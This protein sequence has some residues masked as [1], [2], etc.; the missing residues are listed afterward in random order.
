MSLS[1]KKIGIA[2]TGSF[3]TYARIFDEL[4]ALQKDRSCHTGHSPKTLPKEFDSRFGT[5]ES[6]LKKAEEITVYPSNSYHQRCR[7]N[8]P[9]PLTCLSS[10]LHWKYTCKTCKWNHRHPCLN[11]S[12]SPS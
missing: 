2:F 4:K 3:C 12:K 5:A 10:F 7:A 1:G 6:F 11:G 8:L 9:K